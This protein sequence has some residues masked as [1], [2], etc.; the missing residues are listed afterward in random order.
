MGP[1]QAIVY[2][3]LTKKIKIYGGRATGPLIMIF[4]EFIMSTSVR[5]VLMARTSLIVEYFIIGKYCNTNLFSMIV[6]MDF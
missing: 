6:L 2:G 1:L 3:D 4:S 5:P